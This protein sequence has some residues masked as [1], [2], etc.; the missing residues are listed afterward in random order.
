[1]YSIFHSM[2]QIFIF[3]FE[4]FICIVYFVFHPASLLFRT[5]SEHSK[6]L[7]ERSLFPADL[8]E[9]DLKGLFTDSHCHVCEASLLFESQRIA[10][11]E[12]CECVSVFHVSTLVL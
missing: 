12:V 4:D 11:Y 6:M 9:S 3:C 2:V 5:F 8:G 7:K 1:M 10:H